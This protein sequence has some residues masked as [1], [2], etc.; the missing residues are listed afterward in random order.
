MWRTIGIPFKGNR[1]HGADRSLTE[2]HARQERVYENLSYNREPW[3]IRR[4]LT[5]R[6]PTAKP[7]S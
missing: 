1:R 5:S 7:K 2:D 3:I 4:D 6:S